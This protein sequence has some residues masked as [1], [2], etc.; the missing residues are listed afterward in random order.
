MSSKK[1]TTPISLQ[2]LDELFGT[3]G[4][5]ANGICEV[6]VSSLHSFPNHPFKVRDLYDC[7]IAG[8]SANVPYHCHKAVV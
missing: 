6:S 3:T 2:P 7:R 4:N 8:A 5:S 1:T